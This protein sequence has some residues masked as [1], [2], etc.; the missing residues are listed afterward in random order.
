MKNI[1]VLIVAVQASASFGGESILPLHYYKG[2]KF[3]KNR[4]I[5]HC[6]MKPENVIFTDD[7][8]Q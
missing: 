1:N 5:I 2:L 8:Y 6:D 7:R 4:S 3:M